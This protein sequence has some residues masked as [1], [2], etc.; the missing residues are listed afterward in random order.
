MFD[1]VIRFNF[2]VWYYA[3]PSGLKVESMDLQIEINK[4]RWLAVK[5]LFCRLCPLTS[6][7]A[8]I[9]LV[10]VRIAVSNL[11][12]FVMVMYFNVLVWSPSHGN[13]HLDTKYLAAQI[14]TKGICLV[15]SFF[16]VLLWILVGDT[17]IVFVLLGC[18][19]HSFFL[20]LLEIMTR[21]VKFRN[22]TN[23]VHQI[24]IYFVL[25]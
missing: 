22:S 21:I 4:K 5:D 15:T 3:S 11:W 10:A 16:T 24:F 20:E 19:M 14:S 1:N 7:W 13:T 17:R 12:L 8:S 25:V 23:V 9:A 2:P 6:F 18:L